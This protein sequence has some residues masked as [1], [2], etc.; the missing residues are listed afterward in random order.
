[1]LIY[2]EIEGKRIQLELP[3][4]AKLADLYTVAGINREVY[5]AARN[6]MLLPDEAELSDGDEIKLIKVVSGG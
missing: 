6:G 3:R 5:L 2:V 1:M 4:G